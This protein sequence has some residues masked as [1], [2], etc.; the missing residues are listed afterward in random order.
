MD[1]ARNEGPADQRPVVDGTRLSARELRA[2][3]RA[4]QDG[5]DEQV[6]EARNELSESLEQ[7]DEGLQRLRRRIGARARHA[8]K[9]AAGVAA[10]G[11]TVAVVAGIAW[12]QTGKRATAD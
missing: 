1:T 3:V 2:R 6:A 11:A 5:R 4:L 7:L 10:A 9:V 8:A 12:V